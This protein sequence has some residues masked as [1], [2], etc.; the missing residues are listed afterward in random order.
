MSF[1]R[2]YYHFTWSTKNRLPLISDEIQDK[3]Y[4]YLI[5]KAIEVGAHIYAING[6]NDHV[7]LVAAIPPALAIAIFVKEL[8]GAS[9]H[10]VNYS[11]CPGYKFVWQRGYGV[12]SIGE[13]QKHAAMKYVE[14]QQE[15]HSHQT[16]I[17]WLEYVAD[18]MEGPSDRTVEIGG[19]LKRSVREPIQLYKLD[20][21]SPF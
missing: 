10:Y 4:S 21:E 15:H 14:L 7:H 18:T 1:W 17:P 9:S 8:K 5:G 2:L 3:L 16:S 6:M 12:L 19:G 20:M 13:K 11:L